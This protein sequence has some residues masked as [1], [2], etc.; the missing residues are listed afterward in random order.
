MKR[1]ARFGERLHGYEDRM[2][3]MEKT[4]REIAERHRQTKQE[5]FN[6]EMLEM[7]SNIVTELRRIRDGKSLSNL[8]GIEKQVMRLEGEMN[9]K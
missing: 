4:L 8:A 5:R 7:L 1:K 6:G 2:L 9:F 3:R